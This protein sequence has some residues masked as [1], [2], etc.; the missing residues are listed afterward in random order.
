MIVLATL[1]SSYDRVPTD[2]GPRHKHLQKVIFVILKKNNNNNN[3][4]GPL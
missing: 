4:G 1:F 2:P 3:D